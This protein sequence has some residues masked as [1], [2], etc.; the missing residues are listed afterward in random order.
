MNR[1]DLQDL[2]GGTMGGLIAARAGCAPDN[3]ALVF[4]GE[5]TTYGQLDQ[6]VNAAGAGLMGLGVKKGDVLGIFM[7]NR[8]EYLYACYGASRA[9]TVQVPVNT[10]YKGPFLKY[11]LEHSAASILI[12]EARLG[13]LLLT[14]GELPPTLRTLVYVDGVPAKVP[15]GDIQVLSW[16]EL[17]ARG[18]AQAPFPE[19]LPSDPCAIG[20]TSGTT[21]KSKGVVAPHLQG[22]VMAR[23]TAQAFELTCRDRLY[24]C[25]PLFHGMAQ[26]TTCAAAIYA[27][28][29]IILSPR[30]S[31]SNLWDEVRQA[32]ATQFNA[33]GSMLHMLLSAPRSALDRQH[34]VTRVFAA[35]APADV[36][37]RFE[38]RFNVHVLEGYG[39]TEIKNVIYNPLRGRKIGSMGKPTASS[40]MEIHDGNGRALPPGEIGEIVYRPRMANI[41][42]KE[43]LGNP[44]ATLDSM[45]DLWW[46]T[47]DLGSMDEDGFFYFHDRKS[48]ALRRRGENI[49]SQELEAAVATFPGIHE[50]AAVAVR[51]DIGESEV[52]VVF[53]STAGE[54]FD[55]HALF[56]HCVQHLPRFMVP[57]YYRCLTPMPRTPTGKVRKVALREEGLTSDT[58]DHVAQGLD[59][60]R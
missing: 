36:L 31:V 32:G 11:T 6:R 22:V 7:T 12:T 39:Q 52:L 54:S 57:R 40:I 24:T 60:P 5:E 28:A 15:A 20:F 10:A 41:M 18:S 43:Y 34:N 1:H 14:M 53:E 49:S 4:E 51:S 2:G 27:G 30:F 35:P 8:P 25:L 16:D 59:V 37:Y 48:D 3:V 55:F 33:L 19:L 23:E 56:Q 58:W 45:R 50:A 29:A 42:L 47:G 38:S 9:G 44:Q 13:E 21:G 46:H 26:V 17:L